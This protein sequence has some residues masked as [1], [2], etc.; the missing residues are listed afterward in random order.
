MNLEPKFVIQ[1]P[2]FETVENNQPP[3]IFWID[4]F[5]G[6]GG[7]TSGIEGA[8]T[9]AQVIACVNHDANAILSHQRN[10]PNCLHLTEDVRNMVVVEKL[11][12]LVANYR[13]E[14]PGCYINLWAS[15]ECT[16]Y[17]KAKGGLPR[18]A[19]SRTLAHHLLSYLKALEADYLFI[20]NV[21]EFM[22]WGPL[23]DKGRPV[24][25][26]N[27]RDYLKWKES[28]CQLGYRYD[29]RIINAADHGGYTIRKRYFAQFARVLP[30]KEADCG[31]GRANLPIRWP[32]ASHRGADHRGSNG[33]QSD[34][35]PDDRRSAE[36]LYGKSFLPWRPVREVL[37]LDDVGRSIFTRKKPLAEN[38]LKRIYAGLLKFASTTNEKDF[39]ISYYGRG[40]AHSLS[41]PSY[42]L[43]TR[44]RL[45]RV[46]C[47]KLP[48]QYFLTS[49][50][51]GGGQLSSADRPN[52]TLT[53]VPKQR[54]VACTFIDQQFGQSKP[55][56]VDQP[57]GTL[58][59]NPKFN[60]VAVNRNDAKTRA[61]LLNPQYSNKGSNVDAPSPTLIAR[62]DK[63]PL[64][65]VQPTAAATVAGTPVDTTQTL[66]QHLSLKEDNS[67]TMK[68]IKEFM[69]AHG[70]CDITMRMLN[71]QE[72][73]RI[74]GFPEDYQLVGTMTEKKKFIGNSVHT[75]V[76]RKICEANYNALCEFG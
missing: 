19:D 22:A 18:D 52:P 39:A 28:V 40:S 4:L 34:T 68:L 33:T 35:L 59:A 9:S 38:T 6:A 71:L 76:A 24:S 8:E 54:L 11:K 60:V 63:K 44:D 41:S 66:N 21:V 74:Q 61:W 17:S 29:H 69:A 20:E 64:Y 31:A 1:P 62:M 50:Y 14:H 73:L 57:A 46:V 48:A 72:L 32:E 25:R 36:D 37:D 51:S 30:P 12:S 47:Q 43:T 16:N 67:P 49:Y 53:G 55:A 42:T 27:G 15:L 7:T 10:H 65:L 56:S 70:I 58:T 75:V 2:N 5:C 45:A 23:D 13:S 3:R 26:K